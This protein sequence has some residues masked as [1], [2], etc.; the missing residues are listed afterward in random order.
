MAFALPFLT[1]NAN[2]IPIRG[3]LRSTSILEAYIM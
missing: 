1:E 3:G 2:S